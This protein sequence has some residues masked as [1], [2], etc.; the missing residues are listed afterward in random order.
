MLIRIHPNNLS[1]V[2][3]VK[4]RVFLQRL[5]KRFFRLSIARS[6]KKPVFFAKTQKRFFRLSIV[7][8]VKK[9]VHRQIRIIEK[10][11]YCQ[12]KYNNYMDYIKQR[13]QIN[14]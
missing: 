7:R 12:R 9:P 4:K 6:V 1:I 2:R 13:L 14:R 5:K 3:S 10:G 11:G 8:S